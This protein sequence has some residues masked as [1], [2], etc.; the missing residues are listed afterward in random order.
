MI[1]PKEMQ[2]RMIEEFRANDGK[3]A[4]FGEGESKLLVL[5]SIGAKT[6]RERISMLLYLDWGGSW[7]VFASNGGAPTHP[8]WYHNIIADPNVEIEVGSSKHRA[9][10]RVANEAERQRIWDTQRAVMPEIDDI[11]ANSGRVIPVVVLDPVP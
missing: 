7:A 4:S 9:T 2:A 3:V 10:A 6:G 11:A 1:N 8:A 5:H